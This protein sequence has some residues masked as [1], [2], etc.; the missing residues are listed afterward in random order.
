MI[1][2]LRRIAPSQAKREPVILVMFKLLYSKEMENIKTLEARLN[3]FPF[4]SLRTL[5]TVVV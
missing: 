4:R 3:R 1:G 2:R 5:G